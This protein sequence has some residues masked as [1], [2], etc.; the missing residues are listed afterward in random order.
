M[1][2][3][4]LASQGRLVKPAAYEELLRQEAEA[5]NQAAEELASASP[6]DWRYRRELPGLPEY[7]VRQIDALLDRVRPGMMALELG[8]GSGWLT[9]ALAQRGAT[10]RGIDVA[11]RALSI[12]RTYL[13][14]IEPQVASRVTYQVADLNH[15]DL[16]P[17]GYD[18][19][20]ANGIL[21]HL[22][23]PREM[24][25]R[26][27]QA[28]KPGGLFWVSDK[29]ANETA[30]T[31][32]LASVLMGVLPTHVSY[33]DKFR[34]FLRFGL[35]APTRVRASMEADGFS[36]FE[37]TGRGKDWPQRVCELFDMEEIVEHPAVAGYLTAE[38]RLP[39]PVARPLLRAVAAIDSALVR[40][41]LLRSS[42]LTLAARKRADAPESP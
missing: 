38:V 35:R 3:G 31:V 5:W 14:T 13:Q 32:F 23:D 22:I 10:A 15:L 37:G 2:A 6:P 18:L 27:H 1:D 8:C 26:V 7:T 41:R 12:A 17:A 39:K 24:V 16:P 21:H 40:R 11:D 33:A 36:P 28:L 20:A 34:G 4:P 25:D 30:S 19:V 9:L 29:H 42:G